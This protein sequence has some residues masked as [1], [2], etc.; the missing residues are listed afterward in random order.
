MAV[1]DD[2]VKKN[3]M[4]N[5]D[6]MFVNGVPFL[7]AHDRRIGLVITKY[8]QGQSTKHITKYLARVINKG[9]KGG[10]KAHSMLL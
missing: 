10:F 1:P 8:L 6:A 5:V 7:I 2:V 3:F 4:L 9:R